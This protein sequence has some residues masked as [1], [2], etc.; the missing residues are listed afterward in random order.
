M[1][2]VIILV[3]LLVLAG[4]G[5]FGAMQFAPELLPAPLRDILGVELPEGEEKVEEIGPLVL[6]E[7]EPFTIPLIKDGD[8]DRFLILHMLL[9]VE[10]GE[11]QAY[12]NRALPRIE[13]LIITH[14]HELSQLDVAPGIEDR[15][16]LKERLLAKLEERLGGR[17]IHNLLFQNLFE[18]PFK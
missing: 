16:F 15:S 2:I 4:G 13:D 14:V 11:K 18:R 10:A 6:V 17:Y 5:V 9:E 12:V 1:K 8:V 7:L 3:V